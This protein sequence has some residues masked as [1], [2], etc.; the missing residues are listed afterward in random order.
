MEQWDIY[1]RNR[2]LTGKTICRGQPL[3]QGQYHLMVHVCLFNSRG[4]MLIQLRQAWKKYGDWPNTWDL[5]AGGSA[6]AGDTSATAAQ[7]E[8]A[9]ELGIVLD[10]SCRRPNLSVQ[11]EDGFDDFYLVS[12]DV[13]ETALTLQP[14]EVQ[15]VRW[16]GCDE[17]LA[18]IEREEFIPYYPSLIRLLF[19]MRH[20][21]GGH[22]HEYRRPDSV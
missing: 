2:M 15:R 17:I 7:R 12:M 21:Y 13:D 6:V 1:D 3:P 20:Q 9:E 8:L 16:A 10:F 19:D 22:R 18:M 5:S 14:E 11:Y 4:E